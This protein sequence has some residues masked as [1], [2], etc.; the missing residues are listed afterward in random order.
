M[1]LTGSDKLD[2]NPEF[3]IKSSIKTGFCISQTDLSSLNVPF[4]F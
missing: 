2:A 1:I 4:E 3:L